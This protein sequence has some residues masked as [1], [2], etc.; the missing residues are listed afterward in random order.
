MDVRFLDGMER[1]GK[2]QRYKWIDHDDIKNL[3]EA[4]KLKEA[5]KCWRNKKG[6]EHRTFSECKSTK[7]LT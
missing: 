6:P 1:E 7:S 3:K 2:I 5:S 4:I